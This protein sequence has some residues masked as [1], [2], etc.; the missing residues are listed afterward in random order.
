MISL[1]YNTGIL[2]FK[3]LVGLLMHKLSNSNVPKSLQNVYQCNQNVH[4]HY[5]R[6]ASH[7]HSMRGNNG[8]YGIQLYRILILMCHM[9]V[10]SIYL[11]ISYYLIILTFD[12][13]NKSSHHYPFSSLPVCYVPL[14]IVLII[15]V[16]I[17][18]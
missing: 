6:Q 5:T 16:C 8:L 14:H 17:V 11:K 15:Y 9:L 2:P 12:M 18:W 10:L 4:T 1:Y 13:T 7:V 3:I